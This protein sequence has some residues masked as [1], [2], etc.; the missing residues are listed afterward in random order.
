MGNN[1]SYFYIS[2]LIS[3]SLFSFFALL[4]IFTLFSKQNINVF[5]LKKDN[6]ISISLDIAKVNTSSKKTLTTQ[7]EEQSIVEPN[8]VN[9]DD[10]FNDVWTKNL[11]NKKKVE[12]KVD[13]KR[14]VEIGKKFKKIDKKRV[15]QVLKK[16]ADNS[17]ENKKNDS[18][19]T[20]SANVVNEYLAKIQAL[21]YENFVPPQNS[22]G[23][24][25]KAVIELSSIGKVMDFRILT[26]SDNSNLNEE[27]DKIKSRLIGVLFPVNPQNKTGNY[28]VLLTSKE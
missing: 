9:I 15:E 27:C 18:Q 21:V 11:K 4:I 3:L 1:N 26:Y 5:A 24:T 28:I 2:G 17:M 19:K 13:N 6:Y 14:L 8:D 23:Y 12:K 20:S 25:V 22:Q 10:L 16:T 7:V